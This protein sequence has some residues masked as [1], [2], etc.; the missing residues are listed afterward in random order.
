MT[1]G[2]NQALRPSAFTPAHARRPFDAPERV[3]GRGAAARME[4]LIMDDVHLD[5]A[6][7]FGRE[8]TAST[9]AR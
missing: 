9:A 3:S 1:D 2:T 7:P 4:L 6:H 5:P 8:D